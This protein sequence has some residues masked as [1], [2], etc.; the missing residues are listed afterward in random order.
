MREPSP[1]DGTRGPEPPAT[2]AAGRTRVAALIDRA[3][4]AGTAVVV[5]VVL[6]PCCSWELLRW[7]I[8]RPQSLA[9]VVG[10]GGPFPAGAGLSAARTGMSL[11]PVDRLMA[12]R[13]R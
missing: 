13:Y 2:V 7:V 11:L 9:E 12:A 10:G 1:G 4:T 6:V 8:A 5:L 3:R